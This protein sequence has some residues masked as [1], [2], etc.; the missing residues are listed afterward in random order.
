MW[1]LNTVTKELR[2][3]T[4]PADVPGGYAILSHVWDEGHTECRTIQDIQSLLTF[5]TDDEFPRILAVPASLVETLSSDI[6]WR[7]SIAPK[8]RELCKVAQAHG[9]QWVWTDMCCIDRSCSAE[10]SEAINSMFR[11]YALSGACFVYLHDV[12]TDS[13]FAEGFDSTEFQKSVWHTR[14]WTLQELLAPTFIVFLAHDWSVIGT[15]DSLVSSLHAATK[16]PA[17]VLLL[18]ESLSHTTI[19]QRMCWASKRKTTRVEDEAYCLMGLFGVNMPI[20]YGEGQKAFYRLQEEILKILPDASIFA[21][22]RH[23][24]WVPGSEP[25]FKTLRDD[26]KHIFASGKFLFAASPRPFASCEDI[27]FNSVNTVENL[28]S[29]VRVLRCTSLTP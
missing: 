6:G 17:K 10:L 2:S 16:I 25:I 24:P 23:R 29:L 15:K 22:G 18:E 5:E 20:A 12:H 19:A 14:G 3:F 9:Y 28:V 13:Q 21:W 27:V 26:T 8:I 7:D 1:L 4:S 11:Y